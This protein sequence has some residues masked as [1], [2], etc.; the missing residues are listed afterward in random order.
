MET[1][2]INGLSLDDLGAEGL[3]EYSVG[4]SVISN[5]YFQ[6]RNRTSYNVLTTSFGLKPVKLSL[7]FKGELRRDVM[8]KK[9]RTDAQLFG[10]SEVFL[11][12]GFF[13][14]CMLDSVGEIQ[15]QGQE[16]NGWLAIV[17]YSLNGIQHDQMEEATG[18]T[19]FCRSTTPFTD[20]ALSVTVSQA[21]ESYQLG[22]ATFE[23]VQAGEELTF[24]GINKRILRNGAPAA[25]NVYFINFPQLVPGVNSFSAADPV[26]VK[27]YP[28][29]L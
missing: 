19:F 29:Y 15:W 26:T 21:A 16:G 23:D 17:E 6:G 25:G 27:Y 12:D 18:E 2:Y 11:P 28:S 10:K 4:G 7:A 22:G 3:R 24:D 20:C 5:E 1:I 14:T 8:I 9:S 13:Y